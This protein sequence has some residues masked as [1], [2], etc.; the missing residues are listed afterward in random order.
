M[1]DSRLTCQLGDLTSDIKY[2]TPQIKLFPV[3][4]VEACDGP[5]LHG[6]EH[7]VGVYHLPCVHYHWDAL[8][9]QQSTISIWF[10]IVTS[11]VHWMS[12]WRITFLT[13]WN[14]SGQWCRC[15][16]FTGAWSCCLILTAKCDSDRLQLLMFDV[17]SISGSDYEHTSNVQIEHESDQVNAVKWP[18]NRTWQTWPVQWYPWQKLEQTAF[19]RVNVKTVMS[20]KYKQFCPKLPC[21]S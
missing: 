15:L 10:N 1:S 7:E 20:D 13:N 21:G 12:V 9:Q 6:G 18:E 8:P 11:L 14:K 16:I 4:R 2:Q 5:R 19:V 3:P 17:R